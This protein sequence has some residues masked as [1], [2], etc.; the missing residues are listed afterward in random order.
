M[1]KTSLTLLSL[2]GALT[3]CPRVHAA[4]PPVQIEMRHVNLHLTP[5]ITLGIRHLNGSLVTLGDRRVANLDDKTSYRIDVA[6]GEVALDR[7]GR[8]R[9]ELFDADQW[10]GIF[11]NAGAKYV[12]L[13]SKHHD[14]FALWPS[15]EADATWGR[16]WNAVDVGPKRDL[17][18][19]LTAAVRRQGMEMGFY[20]SLYEWFNPLWLSKD[21]DAYVERHLFPQFKDLVTRYSPSVI[22]SDGEWDLPS[23]RELMTLKS[24]EM[25]PRSLHFTP[26]GHRL[27]FLGARTGVTVWDGTP[28][29]E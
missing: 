14:G 11:R 1:W 12:V 24:P 21:V 25:H 16:D 3:A 6:S 7:A 26:D 8:L 2:V 5:D 20:F 19:E 4:A 22:F 18:G 10:A 23:E 27:I 15:Q 9:A 29:P 17:V 28:L 13:V